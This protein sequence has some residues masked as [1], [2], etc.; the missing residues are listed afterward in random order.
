MIRIA[1]RAVVAMALLG[2]G[3]ASAAETIKW[4][5]VEV[6]PAQ[7]AIWNEAARAFEASHP[8]V[9][10]EPQY[11]ENEAYKAKLTTQLQSRDKPAMFYSWAGG[12]LRAQVQAGVV[13]DLTDRLR[14]YTETL[15]PTAVSA[16][17]IDGRLYGVPQAITDVGFFYNKALFAKAGVDAGAIKTWDDLLAA[18]KKLKAAGITPLT[19]GGAD[20][21][22]LSLFWSYLNVRQAGKAGFEAALKGENG[23]F[24][25]PDFVKAGEYFKQLVDLQPFQNGM[26]GMK[27]LPAI[28]LFADGKAAMT[29]AISVIYNQQAAIAADKKGLAPDQIGWLDFP[30]VPG[31]KGAPT[32][33]LGGI[34]GWV[35][36]KGAPSATPDFLKS[37]VS[38]E[39]QGKL[40]AA[41]FI[42]PVVRGADEAVSNPFMKHIADQLAHSTYHQNFY[43]Q[44]LGPSVGRTVNDAV[45]EIAGGSMTPQEAAQAVQAAYKQGN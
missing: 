29:L 5:H 41:G 35:V 44:V 19:A 28:G 38:P 16:F 2:A 6:N 1:R 20:K 31:G 23:G 11:L 8:G 37:F 42:I 14:G 9:K 10:V 33:T 3:H 32:D 27:H 26:L 13:E 17:T 45:A 34:V 36:S 22:P 7:I 12:V 30:T 21:W 25:G 43:D 40:A 24:A 4:L 15:T 39:V 18:V